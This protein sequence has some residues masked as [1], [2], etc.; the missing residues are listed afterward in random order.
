MSGRGLNK[1]SLQ[2]L[3]NGIALFGLTS[4]FTAFAFETTIGTQKRPNAIAKSSVFTSLRP[5]SNPADYVNSIR[6]APNSENSL[7]DQI[8]DKEVST[9]RRIAIE[10]KKA[11]RSKKLSKILD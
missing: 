10:I 11:I 9:G 3:N 5:E 6:K 1:K 2:M 8:F 4:C 7:Q